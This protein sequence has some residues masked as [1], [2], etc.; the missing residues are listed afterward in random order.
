MTFS[1]FLFQMKRQWNNQ[2][3]AKKINSICMEDKTPMSVR[4]PYSHMVENQQ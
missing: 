3:N 1:E 4:N 2:Q